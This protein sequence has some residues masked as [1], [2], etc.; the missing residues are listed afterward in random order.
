MKMLKRVAFALLSTTLLA[1][2][3]CATN[4]PTVANDTVPSLSGSR[5][6]YMDQ[7][8]EYDITFTANGVLR[9]THP[10][11]KTP[12]NDTWEQDG[13]VVKFYYNNKFSRYQGNIMG[14]NLMSGTATN[15][16]NKTW[17]W[18]ATRVD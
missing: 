5:W 6:H 16:K 9:T 12:D 4:T 11:D 1:V 10:N 14:R 13:A 17:T 2:N 8:W 15:S 3:G 18:K 7:Q